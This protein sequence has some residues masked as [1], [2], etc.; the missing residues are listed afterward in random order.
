MPQLSTRFVLAATAAAVTAALAFAAPAQATTLKW[1]T[2]KPQNAGDAQAIS[3]Q[4]FVDEFKK[5]TGGKSEIKMF[6]GGSVAKDRE[7]PDFLSGGAADMG[8]IITPYFPD[9][10]PL[11]NTVGYFIPQ[12][13]STIE[14]AEMMEY[15]HRAYPQFDA[16]MKKYNL[17]TIGFR[18]LEAYGM[19]CAKP[20]KSI[21]DF[22]GKR[23]RTYGFAYPAFVQALG[24]TPV[25][26]SSS[27]GYEALQRG[28][29][30]C[31]PIGP[32]LAHGWKY[33]EVAKY[34]I[35][36]PI[37]ASFGHMITMNRKSY[38]SLDEATRSIL[39]GLGREYAMR[40]TTD[41]DIL[42]KKIYAGWKAKGVTVIRL[43]KEQF[44]KIIDFP[45]VKAVRQKWVDKAKAAG[46]STDDI[47]N[48]FKF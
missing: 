9:K 47:V 14:I 36:I 24:G 29:L 4:W 20:I 5:R 8:D 45:A 13:H 10:F 44:A 25:S 6:W 30:D 34:Y 41:L 37:G 7:I 15:W 43:P 42:T 12:P 28:I 23:I 40:Y 46:V 2:F 33:D 27:D 1:I 26:M 35:E 22:K 18:P 39:D 32:S 38:D 11:N 17:K 48:E 19:I 16:E 3:T 31:S 21:E